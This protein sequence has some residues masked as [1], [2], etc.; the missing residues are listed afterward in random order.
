[1]SNNKLNVPVTINLDVLE[2][3]IT[4]EE[5]CAKLLGKGATEAHVVT[6]NGPGGGSAV[7]NARFPDL[8]M[9][10]EALLELNYID[11]FEGHDP[12]RIE[13]YV[14]EWHDADVS[15]V[16]HIDETS[17]RMLN[18]YTVQRTMNSPW[19]EKTGD[20]DLKL[21]MDIATAYINK[22][23]DR[24]AKLTGGDRTRIEVDLIRGFSDII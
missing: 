8:V 11:E 22:L 19:P 16:H 5:F 14:K 18:T 21:E 20:E 2:D 4:A 10:H 12:S 9:A 6:H 24:H 3:D 13:H 17:S 7:V 23:L 1:M 15:R